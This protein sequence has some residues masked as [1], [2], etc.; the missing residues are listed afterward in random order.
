MA[1]AA[2]PII[3]AFSP[4]IVS[5]VTW[6]VKFVETK[7]GPKTGPTKAGTVLDMA[8]KLFEALATA[9]IIP[10]PKNEEIKALIQ[11]VVDTLNKQGALVGG[12]T[13][14]DAAL[15]GVLTTSSAP[16]TSGLDIQLIVGGMKFK[17]VQE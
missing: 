14:I 11:L 1:A 17:Y 7:F 12:E 5:G 6:L 15:P 16:A 3:T 4:L 2:I 13:K 8:T 9:G 10:L